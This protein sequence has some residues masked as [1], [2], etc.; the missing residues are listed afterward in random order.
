[1]KREEIVFQ[2]EGTPYEISGVWEVPEGYYG[3]AVVLVSGSGPVDRDGNI[4]KW[5]NNLYL[6]FAEA[7]HDLGIA[8]FRYDKPGTGKSKG[9]YYEAGLSDYIAVGVEALRKIKDRPEVQMVT[10]IGHS[11]GALIGPAILA[12]VPADGFVFFSGTVGR[13]DELLSFQL[14]ELM[15]EFQQMK[16]IKGFLLRL[17]NVE[18]KILKQNQKVL[19]KMRNTTE[20][21]IRYRGAQLNAKWYREMLTY[22]WK[23]YVYAIPEYSMAIEGGRDIQVQQ[24]SAVAFAEMT[25]TKAV[26]IPDMNHIMR[27][28]ATPHSLLAI[29]K[30]YKKDFAEQPVHPELIQAFQQFFDE[31]VPP[32]EK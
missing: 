26:V 22:D 2:V 31:A 23:D 8:T 13:G 14:D 7:L 21:K 24:G 16:G 17:I 15:N 9:D 27:R 20:V 5:K 6:S 10:L 32:V 18:K 12:Q 28:R 3:K 4:P 11:E 30:E 25:G 29:Q 19:A 1:M